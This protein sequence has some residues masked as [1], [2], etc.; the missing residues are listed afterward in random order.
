MIPALY[1]HEAESQVVVVDQGDKARNVQ[2]RT[3]DESRILQPVLRF[4]LSTAT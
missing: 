2:Q 4:S 1:Q 3:H